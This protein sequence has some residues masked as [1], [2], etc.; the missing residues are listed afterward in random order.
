[1]IARNSTIDQIKA[2]ACLL[3]IGHHLAFYGPMS[4]ALRSSLPHFLFWMDEYARM[5]VQVFL[6]FGGYFAA[7]GLAPQ[8]TAQFTA[9]WPALSQRFIRLSLPYSAALVMAIVINET[10]RGLG[11]EHPSVSDTPTWMGLLAHLLLLQSITGYE[12]LSAGIWY[13]AIDFQLYAL[14][15]LWFWLCSKATRWAGWAQLGIAALTAASL[16]IW[17]LNTDGDNWCLYFMGAYGLGI[18][19]WWATHRTQRKQ[20]ML[21]IAVIV[22]LGSSA[23]L[24]EWR[25]R[26]AIAA[27]SA[28]LLAVC[29]NLRWPAAWRGFQ[30]APLTWI[31][32]RSYSIFLIH[33]PMCLLV[34]AEVSRSWPDSVAANSLGIAFAMLLS[35][36]AGAA[37]YDCT[38]NTKATWAHLRR[39]QVGFLS[40][41]ALAAL[42]QWM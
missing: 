36:A 16:W 3:I 11:F 40:T 9:F 4:D 35:I 8:G 15:L 2:I 14:C 6:V 33:F 24:L 7:A 42:L 39:W 25:D 1:M 12:S 27:V 29:G 10:V 26:I 20:R 28:W 22:A 19:A 21:W 32:Q 34:N 18:M 41:G 23:L 13:V 5:A 30:I 38:E 37:L 31:G 17:N